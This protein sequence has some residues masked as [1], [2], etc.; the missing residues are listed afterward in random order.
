MSNNITLPLKWH[1]GK[2]GHNGKLARWIVSLMPRHLSYVESYAGG[3][4]V[5]LARDPADPT[6]WWQGPTSDGSKVDGVIEVVNDLNGD[7]VNFYQV[8]RDPALFERLRHRLDLTPLAEGEWEFA[9]RAL[10]AGETADPVER[11]ALM[12]VFNRQSRQGLMKD[13]ATP[14]RTRLRGGRSDPVNAWWSAVE[15]LESVHRRLQDVMFFS[16]P[17]LEVIRSEDTAATLHYCD[18]PYVHGARTATRAYGR[19]EMAEADH[20]ELLETLAGIKGKFMLSGYRNDLYDAY[21]ERHGWR[22]EELVVPNH[23]SGSR[24]KDREVECLWLNF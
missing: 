15:G 6:L 8:L 21:A 5:L 17:A 1:G 24:K 13:F 19:Y 12:Y 23:A 9:R 7:L 20:R 10:A 22:R 4:A 2:G 14:V 11:A 16:R 18:P 3:L